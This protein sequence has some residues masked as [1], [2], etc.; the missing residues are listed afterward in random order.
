VHVL[1]K[2]YQPADVWAV[3]KIRS[4]NSAKTR[5]CIRYLRARLRS[6]PFAL[7]AADN[8]FAFEFENFDWGGD[9]FRMIKPRVQIT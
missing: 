3:T 7:A 1:R 9:Y 4:D 8:S 6:G 5:L 2:F